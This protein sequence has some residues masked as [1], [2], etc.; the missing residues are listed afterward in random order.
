MKLHK[1]KNKGNGKS[2]KAKVHFRDEGNMPNKKKL[3]A[4]LWFPLAMTCR[5][6]IIYTAFLKTAIPKT[7]WKYQISFMNKID[8]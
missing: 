5:P 3:W 7:R 1:Q 6:K 4:Y 8:K 2:P